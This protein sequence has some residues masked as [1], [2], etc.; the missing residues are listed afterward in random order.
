[1]HREDLLPIEKA[2]AF[3]RLLARLQGSD[4]NAKQK[5]LMNVVNLSEN[6]ISEILKISRLDGQIK[7]EALKSKKW[8]TNKLLQLAKIKN[9]ENRLS[10]FEEYKAV[11]N[12]T[13]RLPAKESSSPESLSEPQSLETESSKQDKKIISLLS[14]SSVF[15]KH[16]EKSVKIKLSDSE[17]EEFKSRLTTIQDLFNQILS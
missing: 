10:R 5:A 17:K 1:L 6:Y 13:P 15:I 12:K 7:E 2:N 3:A 4:E 16:L 9:D 8:S 11:I 14:R